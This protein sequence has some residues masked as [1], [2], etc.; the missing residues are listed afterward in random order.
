MLLHRGSVNLQNKS[1]GYK[2]AGFLQVNV[3]LSR[4]EDEHEKTGIER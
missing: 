4:N 1:I 2:E 3:F